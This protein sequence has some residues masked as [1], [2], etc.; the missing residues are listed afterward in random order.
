MMKPVGQLLIFTAILA[1]NILLPSCGKETVASQQDKALRLNQI[2]VIASHNS[3]RLMT[4]DTVFRY[5][6]RVASLLPP[7]FNPIELDYTHSN[8]D[9]QFSLY[10]VRGLEIDVYNDP[11]GGSFANRQIHAMI[12]IPLESNI[13]EL[14][15]PGF[16][17]LHIKDVDYNSHYNTFVQNL[18][19]VKAWSDDHPNHLP[20]FINIETKEDSPA[21]NPTLVTLGFT[22][23]PPQDAAAADALDLEIKSVFGNNLDKIITPDKLRGNLPTLNDVVIQNKW[24]MLGD[25]RGKIIFI[26][27]GRLVSHYLAGHPSLSGR[28]CFVY[29]T[30]GQPEA[31]FVILNNSVGDQAEI[32]QR[33]QQGY[34]V[35]TRT[36]AGTLEARAGNYAPMNSAFNSGAQIIS[37]DY[38]RPDP[39]GNIPGSGWTNFEVGFP[40]APL[41]RKNPVNASSVEVNS[42]LE[43]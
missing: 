35:R 27:E 4:T 41:G 34:I 11:V 26:M 29:A 20:I 37:T 8:Y 38:Y 39:R 17:V 36:D 3:Y 23:P 43:E 2:Q 28:A 31:A 19:A 7:E 32:T 16:K 10:G 30:P 1:L 33:V 40:D 42:S 22:P 25:C 9:Q 18:Q 6:T 21:D 24:P 14:N 13:L 15:Q 12:E 5:L